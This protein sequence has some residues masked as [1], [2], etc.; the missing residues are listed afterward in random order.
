MT[1]F[2]TVYW[3]VCGTT[4]VSHERD[5]GGIDFYQFH[6]MFP[7]DT[8]KDNMVVKGNNEVHLFCKNF[9]ERAEIMFILSTISCF[10]VVISLV[11]FL[12]ALSANYAHIRGQNKFTELQDLQDPTS[13]TMTL[14]ERDPVYM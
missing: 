3:H 14:T 13:E 4:E 10:L 5:G 7:K 12:M 6:F 11:H 9:I 1:T 2:T 8:D